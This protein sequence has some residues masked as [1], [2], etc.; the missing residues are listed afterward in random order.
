MKK[1]EIS[2][3]VAAVMFLVGAFGLVRFL[4]F[5]NGT[6]LTNALMVLVI[7]AVAIIA[8]EELR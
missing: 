7:P 1:R 8:R 6:P 4:V 5:Q 2:Y 3:M